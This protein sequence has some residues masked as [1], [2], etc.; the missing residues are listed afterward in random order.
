MSIDVLLL[1]TLLFW[2]RAQKL[3]CSKRLH[4]PSKESP[5]GPNTYFQTLYLAVSVGDT[6]T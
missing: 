1:F 2:G 5:N 3:R 4:H 6:H